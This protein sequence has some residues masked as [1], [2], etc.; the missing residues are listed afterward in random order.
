MTKVG[1]GKRK[2]IVPK[3][4]VYRADFIGLV[5]GAA[6]GLPLPNRPHGLPSAQINTLRNAGEVGQP[7]AASSPRT[8]SPHKLPPPP[9]STYMPT[10]SLRPESIL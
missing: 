6:H 10:A 3:F 5:S 2:F 1:Q 9:A 7:M 4:Q 8:S